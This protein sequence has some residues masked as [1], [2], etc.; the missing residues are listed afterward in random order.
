[1]NRY[2]R[3]L[4]LP[5]IG[6]AGQAR[7][8]AA[9]VLLIGC[10]ALGSVAAM[11]LA[12][13]GIGEL[14]IADFDSVEISNLHRQLFY[15]EAEVGHAKALLL[16]NR[17]NAL[18]SEVR[19]RALQEKIEARTLPEL[20]LGSDVVIEATDNAASKYVVAD[21]CK[22]LGVP[23]IIGGVDGWQGQL[24]VQMPASAAYST[25]FPPAPLQNEASANKR[26]GVVGPVPGV[27]GSLQAAEAIK[28]ILQ[29][30]QS[31]AGRLLVADILHGNFQTIALE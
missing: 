14:T 6:A 26:V 25:I 7:L 28:I 10:G 16:K 27:I 9:S 23:C 19:V 20:M 12:G 11:Y 13:A 30:G 8:Q 4:Q 18:N 31:L 2:S 5:E 17:I 29:G 15:A 24:F 3:Q 21:T 22:R 1:M